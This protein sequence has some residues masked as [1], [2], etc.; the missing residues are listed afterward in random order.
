[1]HKNVCAVGSS[2]TAGCAAPLGARCIPWG[3]GT[4]RTLVAL[5]EQR[6]DTIAAGIDPLRGIQRGVSE[7][8]WRAWETA[9]A[10][11]HAMRAGRCEARPKTARQ[12]DERVAASLEAAFAALAAHYAREAKASRR[13]PTVDPWSRVYGPR[14]LSHADL[15]HRTPGVA[16]GDAAVTLPCGPTRPVASW[17]REGFERA[18]G[19]RSL[20]RGVGIELSPG[21]RERPMRS[22]ERGALASAYDGV[23]VRVR[24]PRHGERAARRAAESRGA[25][26]AHR[27]DAAVKAALPAR[28]DGS[29]RPHALD[30]VLAMED[31]AGLTAA[32]TG[33]LTAPLEPLARAYGAAVVAVRRAQFGLT[34]L[35]CEACLAAARSR[36]VDALVARAWGHALAELDPEALA[37]ERERLAELNAPDVARAERDALPSARACRAATERA[38][39][40]WEDAR[41]LA[42]REDRPEPARPSVACVCSQGVKRTARKGRKGDRP[43]P[44]AIVDRGIV[45][46][47]KA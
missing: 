12:C 23:V 1:M 21:A 42:A 22:W 31:A 33:A 17:L 10:A 6:D 30:A 44:V 7:R 34:D 20:R 39:L 18:E 24:E 8:A 40:A 29:A 43:A 5:R 9:V 35:P 36:I 14:V 11:Y 4:D 32:L 27:W 46:P 41:V 47:R 45:Q 3:E 37:A 19:A 13:A 2:T 25:S 28:E 16:Y 15:D 38:L 26:V